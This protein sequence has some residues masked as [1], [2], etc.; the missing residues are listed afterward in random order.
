MS[1]FQPAIDDL[2]LD[3]ETVDD[4]LEKAI[5]QH[6]YPYVDG[7][8]T[9]DL[10]VKARTFRVK[11]WFLNER[12]FT[13]F[14][15]LDHIKGRDLF[16]FVHPEIG[17]VNCRIKSV[18]VRRD[19]RIETAEIDLDLIEHGLAATTYTA[20]PQPAAGGQ[21]AEAFVAAQPEIADSV[22]E[23]AAETLGNDKAIL[24]K[25]LNPL[26]T[27]AEQAAGIK[28][29]AREYLKSLDTLS[30]T[31]NNWTADI[32]NAAS[33]VLATIDYPQTVAGRVTGA[34]AKAMERSARA[35]DYL[36]SAPARFM[37]SL[38]TDLARI[39]YAAGQLFPGAAMAAASH[40]L[41]LEGAAIL[42]ADNQA[43]AVAARVIGPAFDNLG[44][45]IGAESDENP[46]MATGDFETCLAIA[47]EA[48]QA[49]IDA[50]GRDME[51][52]KVMAA[53]LLAAGSD[54]DRE[55]P[56]TIEINGP[57]PLHLVCLMYGL[58]IARAEQLVAM[59]PSL[60]HPSFAMGEVKIS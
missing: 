7:A 56:R 24:E 29:M 45:L 41:S 3:L 30:D 44:R 10:G 16:E 34:L 50:G 43:R 53:A 2:P 51:T 9:E 6:D 22:N 38:Q 13:H 8:D 60:E 42:D 14:A 20:R 40:R 55:S 1:R 18:N 46:P 11:C 5:A 37:A 35:R 15:F 4:G 32:D 17:P 19:D 57:L 27:I 36:L 49:A 25:T 47:R 59:N 23:V 21:V 12:Y 52:L 31:L 39:S 58:P 33:S 28:G 54:P 26:E 48:I